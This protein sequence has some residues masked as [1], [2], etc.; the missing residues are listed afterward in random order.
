MQEGNTVHLKLWCRE[1][2]FYNECLS[3]CVL[4]SA[5]VNLICVFNS[6]TNHK[7]WLLAVYWPFIGSC[8]VQ[9]KGIDLCHTTTWLCHF[10]LCEWTHQWKGQF[11]ESSMTLGYLSV[12][13]PSVQSQKQQIKFALASYLCWSE[14]AASASF[15]S[16]S[17]LWSIMKCQFLI[18]WLNFTGT[19]SCC[20]YG[21]LCSEWNTKVV[22]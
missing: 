3:L 2:S 13:K 9:N 8:R 22:E 4:N 18:H 12:W 20:N 6:P 1:I 21:L 15:R 10:S 11:V 5:V 16:W 17:L 7:P 19:R 14:L